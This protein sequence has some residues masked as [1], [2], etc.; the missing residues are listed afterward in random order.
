MLLQQ[1]CVK[2]VCVIDEILEMFYIVRE[3]S[4][5]DGAREMVDNF[6]ELMSVSC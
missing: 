2:C 3:E 4:G 6:S 1:A 5:M